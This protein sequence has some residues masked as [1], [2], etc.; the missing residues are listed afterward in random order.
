MKRRGQARGDT[1]QAGKTGGRHAASPLNHSLLGNGIDRAGIK[2][3]LTFG[4]VIGD[5]VFV[6]R[7][8]DR[9]DRTR[10]N[11]GATSNA[12]FSDLKSHGV[13]SFVG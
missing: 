9:P 13:F 1:K 10:V 7:F 5:G 2:A 4:A 8:V 3:S 6:A 11:T 12:V